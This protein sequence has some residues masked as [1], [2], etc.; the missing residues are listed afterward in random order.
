R[1]GSFWRQ[2]RRSARTDAGVAAGNFDQS[3]SSDVILL[4]IS[5]GAVPEKARV[6][7]SSSYMTHPNDQISVRRS[8]DLPRACSGDMYDTVPR[9]TLGFVVARGVAYNPAGVF[10]PNI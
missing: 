2:C 8:N 7:V 5:A 4:M 6:P 1:F 10:A 3:A 9:T